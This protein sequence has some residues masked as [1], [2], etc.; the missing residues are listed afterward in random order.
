MPLATRN[1][2]PIPYDVFVEQLVFGGSTYNVEYRRNIE[3][4]DVFHSICRALTYHLLHQCSPGFPQRF[5]DPKES[6]GELDL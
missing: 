6:L 2:Y 4:A 3:E 5:R 1:A